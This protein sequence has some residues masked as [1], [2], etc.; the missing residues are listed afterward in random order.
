MMR[1]ISTKLFIAGLPLYRA[2]GDEMMGPCGS[3]LSAKIVRLR[4]LTGWPAA[5]GLVEMSDPVAV[6]KALTV[7]NRNPLDGQC[8]DAFV[9]N[10]M[11]TL[12][13][14]GSGGKDE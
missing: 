12:P 8:L 2:A 1:T 14:H 10:R 11:E 7:L 9:G 6:R 4:D 13:A 5:L 3:V